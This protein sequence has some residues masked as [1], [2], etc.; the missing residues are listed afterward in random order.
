M[1]MRVEGFF[2]L[3]EKIAGAAGIDPV[4]LIA[5]KY[6]SYPRVRELRAELYVAALAEEFDPRFIMACCGLANEAKFYRRAM[7]ACR[8]PQRESIMRRCIARINALETSSDKTGRASSSRG[9]A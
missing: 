8:L 6:E 4:W 1:S 5:K 3:A 7:A 9:A 2:R